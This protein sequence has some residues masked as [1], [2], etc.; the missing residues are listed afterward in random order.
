MARGGGHS[1]PTAFVED[2]VQ[3][4]VDAQEL[5]FSLRSE[6]SALERHAAALEASLVRLEDASASTA[7]LDQTSKKAR[8]VTRTGTDADADADANSAEKGVRRKAKAP[9]NDDHGNEKLEVDGVAAERTGFAHGGR[10]GRRLRSERRKRAAAVL[11]Q[12]LGEGNGGGGGAEPAGL[13]MVMPAMGVPMTQ[14]EEAR[15]VELAREERRRAQETFVS[16]RG[17]TVGTLLW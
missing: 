2:G 14:G 15:A 8:W 4:A 9:S 10:A 5:V 11:R 17:T 1:Y 12:A 16:R 13:G 7:H 3:A 6:V